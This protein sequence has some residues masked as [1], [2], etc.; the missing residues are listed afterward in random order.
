[1]KTTIGPLIASNSESGV[2]GA[3]SGMN[4]LCTEWNVYSSLQGDLQT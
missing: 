2:K 1:M 3:A 4:D